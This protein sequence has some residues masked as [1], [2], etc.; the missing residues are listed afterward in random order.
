M[1]NITEVKIKKLTDLI[2]DIKTA[3]DNSAFGPLFM[4]PDANN[5]MDKQVNQLAWNLFLHVISAELKVYSEFNSQ[6]NQ[7]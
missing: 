2:N 7:D 1:D 6:E 4:T 5:I 3:V